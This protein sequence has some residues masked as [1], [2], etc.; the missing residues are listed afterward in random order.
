MRRGSLA[1]TTSAPV[2]S[3][4]GLRPVYHRK[5]SRQE[6]HLFITVLAYHLLAIIQRELK[7]KGLSHR[8]SMLRTRLSTHMRATA[9]VTNDKG[10]RIYLRQTGDPEPFHLEVYRTLGLPANPLKTKR[11]MKL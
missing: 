7:C 1:P 3:E 8:W 6:G 9:S 10:E 2:K 5:A 4:L 11:I